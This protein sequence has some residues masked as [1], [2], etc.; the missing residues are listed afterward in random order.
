MA[1]A[2]YAYC[3]PHNPLSPISTAV[4]VQLDACTPN[5]LIQEHLSD[6]KPFRGKWASRETT[7]S[8]ARKELL[9]DAPLTVEKSYIKV[10]NGPGLGIKVNEEVFKKYPYKPWDSIF[11]GYLEDG[12]LGGWPG[13]H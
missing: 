5:F 9:I 10:P 8:F 4:A 1:E 6:V 12:S 2:Y 3:A 13:L 11:I 7:E